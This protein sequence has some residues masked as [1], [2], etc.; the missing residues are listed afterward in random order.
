MEVIQRCAKDF[1]SFVI[2]LLSPSLE[3]IPRVLPITSRG[4]RP[5]RAY[6]NNHAARLHESH[7]D[8][9]KSIWLDL[10]GYLFSR[11]PAVT[12]IRWTY[13]LT[14]NGIIAH[15]TD[16]ISEREN[17]LNDRQHARQK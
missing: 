15:S 16:E 11:L 12:N 5:A 1:V 8:G 14:M 6:S 13:V 4:R 9:S 3:I 10:S 7:K 17:G 2:T